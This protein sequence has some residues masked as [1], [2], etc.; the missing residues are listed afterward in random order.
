MSNRITVAMLENV[1]NSIND[2]SKHLEKPIPK[3]K[4]VNIKAI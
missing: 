1:I 2:I 3:T 4:T